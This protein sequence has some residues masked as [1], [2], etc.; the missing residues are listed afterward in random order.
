MKFAFIAENVARFSIRGMCRV[1]G[2]SPS[3]YYASLS[4]PKSERECDN[5][6]LGLEIEAIHEQSRGTYGSPRITRELQEQGHRVSKKRVA[7]RMKERGIQG[8][9]RR[10][11]RKTTDSKHGLPVAPNLLARDFTQDAPNKVW[12]TDVTAI[13]GNGLALSSCHSGPVQSRGGGLGNELA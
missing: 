6:L 10:R 11:F 3:G 12:V 5:E 4:R 13:H 7:K 9:K 2:V 8:K 1:L